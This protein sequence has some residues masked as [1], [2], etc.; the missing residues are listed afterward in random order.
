MTTELD[1]RRLDHLTDAIRARPEDL[2]A[3]LM[4]ERPKL[5]GAHDGTTLTD[6]A[7][8]DWSLHPSV[9]DWIMRHLHPGLRTLETG[10]GY[11][12]IVF[13]LWACR[14]QSVSPFPEEHRSINDWCRAHGASVETVSYRTGPSQLVLPALNATPLDLVLIDGDHAVPLPLIDFFYT[15]DR[16]VEDGWLLVDDVQLRSVQQLSAFLDTETP[17]WAFVEQVERTRI[18]RKRVAGRVTGLL[19]REQPFCATRPTPPPQRSLLSRGLR[20]I[21]RA[22]SG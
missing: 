4:R 2:Y 3:L 6:A 16:L 1:R 8:W 22:L 12:T 19:W 9:L 15:A 10:C 14:H 11:S 20:K 7:V 17:R 18:Y 21:R 5:H 13:A